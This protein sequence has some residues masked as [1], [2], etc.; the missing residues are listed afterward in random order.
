MNETQVKKAPYAGWHKAVLIG[1][2]VI[3]VLGTLGVIGAM[4]KMTGTIAD[5]GG[6]V[7]PAFFVVF[8]MVMLSLWLFA[9]SGALLIYIAKTG[10]DI[11]AILEAGRD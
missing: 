2:L 9:G 11:K 6:S 7:G 10:T 5:Y 4:V 3:A 8:I 1:C